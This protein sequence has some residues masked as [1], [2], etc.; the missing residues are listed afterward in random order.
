MTRPDD[1]HRPGRTPRPSRTTSPSRPA[2]RE[3]D[4]ATAERSGRGSRP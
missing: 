1:T 4:E 2:T 3:T